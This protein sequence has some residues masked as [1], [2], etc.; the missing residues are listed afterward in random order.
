MSRFA[1]E[2]DGLSAF[3]AADSVRQSRPRCASRSRETRGKL[4]SDG[5]GFGAR[6]FVATRRRE[7][8]LSLSNFKRHFQRQA[9]DLDVD[10]KEA[11]A[12]VAA[13]ARPPATVENSVESRDNWVETGSGPTI[14]LKQCGLSSRELEGR[15]PQSESATGNERP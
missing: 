9:A 12:F 8:C 3:E 10:E 2:P 1:V 7:W 15:A 6:P 11:A 14:E 13:A 5:V 4:G